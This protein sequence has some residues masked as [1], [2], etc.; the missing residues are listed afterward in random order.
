MGAW[1]LLIARIVVY[2]GAGVETVLAAMGI[3][4]NDLDYLRPILIVGAVVWIVTIVC[5]VVNHQRIR[6]DYQGWN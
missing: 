2:G 3:A 4:A 6:R 5:V 1:P